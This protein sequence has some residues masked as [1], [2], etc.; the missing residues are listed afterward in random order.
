MAFLVSL[1]ILCDIGRLEKVQHVFLLYLAIKSGNAIYQ[2]SHDYSSI[3]NQFCVPTL[4]SHRVLRDAFY[5]FKITNNFINGQ[6]LLDIF[7]LRDIQ[8]DLRNPRTY[9]EET[10][11][12][13]KCDFQCKQFLD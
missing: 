1:A 11:L 9:A 12:D 5:A 7:S 2:F 13:V 6:C 10:Y 3:M 8:Y 4:E